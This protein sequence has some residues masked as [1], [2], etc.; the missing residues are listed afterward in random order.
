MN[1]SSVSTIGPTRPAASA[2]NSR[3]G[4]FTLHDESQVH[5]RQHPVRFVGRQGRYAGQESDGQGSPQDI[6]C[7]RAEAGLLAEPPARPKFS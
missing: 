2:S 6:I 1:R 5:R 7:R 4:G 3:K